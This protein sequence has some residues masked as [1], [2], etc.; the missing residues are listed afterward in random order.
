MIVDS[1]KNNNILKTRV[2]FKKVGYVLNHFFKIVVVKK[3][4]A[5]GGLISHVGKV[6][7]LIKYSNRA[8]C[9]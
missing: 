6:R 3:H 7:W 2:T 1:G 4:I 9:D 5:Q 8:T